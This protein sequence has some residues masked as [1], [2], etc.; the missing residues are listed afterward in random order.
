[1]KPNYGIDTPLV[2]I[3]LLLFGMVSMIFGF[4]VPHFLPDS[5]PVASSIFKVQFILIGLVLVFESFFMV[6]TSLSG[7]KKFIEAICRGLQLK[8]DEKVVDLGCAK[9]LFSIEIAKHLST[10]RVSAIDRFRRM[11]QK[12]AED[13]ARIEQVLEKI[14]FVTGDIGALPFPQQSFDLAISLLALHDLKSKEER[15]KALS[16]MSRVLKP[17]SRLIIVD[18]QNIPEYAEMLEGLGWQDIQL[19]KRNFKLFPPLRVLFA[20]R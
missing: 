16:E 4:L 3:L 20:R 17:S 13:N 7:K 1:M 19:S 6:Y 18:M 8:G 12:C 10:G 15:L 5:Y 14:Q 11:G 9:G 2:I